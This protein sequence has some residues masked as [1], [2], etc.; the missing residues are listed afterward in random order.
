MRKPLIHGT[1]HAH[2]NGC[3]CVPCRAAAADYRRQLR[4]KQRALVARKDSHDPRD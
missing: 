4:H 1:K 2:D 3:R